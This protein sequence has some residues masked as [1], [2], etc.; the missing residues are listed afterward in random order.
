MEF[1]KKYAEAITLK[2]NGA[3]ELGDVV[4][5]IEKPKYEDQGDLAFPCFSLAKVLRNS[6]NKIASELAGKIQSPLFTKVVVNGAYVNCFLN[7]LA[8]SKEILNNILGVGTGYGSLNMG[9]GRHITI[10]FSSPNIA[11]P[12]S[13]GHLRSTKVGRAH[14]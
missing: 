5:L 8:V 13:M 1:I 9:K 11:K 4:D 12:F 14:V 2:L 10:D 3:L 7:R 6:P